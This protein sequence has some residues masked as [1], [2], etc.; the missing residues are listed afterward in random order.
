M[1][2]AEAQRIFAETN[3]EYPLVEGVAETLADVKR[4]SFRESAVSLTELGEMNESTIEMIDDVAL[5]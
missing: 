2:T 1:L 4:G 3:F 5:E